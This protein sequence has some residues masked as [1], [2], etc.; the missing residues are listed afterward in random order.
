M[1]TRDQRPARIFA[2]LAVLLAALL[3][4]AVLP[5]G[6][7]APPGGD[8]PEQAGA[9]GETPLPA[10]TPSGAIPQV[11]YD[12]ALLP[13]PV[14]RLRQEIIAAARTGDIDLLRPILAANGITPVFSF[15]GDTDAIGFWKEASG[16]GE[17]RELL[18]IM[19]EVFE[20]GFV[21]VKHDGRNEI[22]VWPYF[23]ELPLDGLTAEQQVELYKLVTAQDVKDME[24]FGAYNFYRAGITPDGQWQFFVAGD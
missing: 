9:P 16:D 21:R 24:A 13:E 5:A 14:A 11:L 17:G 10:E 7:F 3:P 4:A 20:A 8:P 15:G 18:A 19:I 22:Y 2:G 23:A 1:P 12:L 6:G